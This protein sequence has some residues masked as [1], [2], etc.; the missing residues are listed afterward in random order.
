MKIATFNI[1]GIKARLPRLLEWLEETKPDVACLQEIKCLDEN[2]PRLEFEALGYQLAI[3]G[4]K[5]FNG[6]AIFSRHEMQDIERGLPGDENDIQSRYLEATVKGVRICCLYLPN[7]N[8]VPGEKFDYKLAWMDRLIARAKILLASEVPFLMLG[9]FNV[10]QEEIDCYD[11]AAFA[12]DA[13]MQPDARARFRALK[14]LGLTDAS[15]QKTPGG[16]LYTFWDYQR[17]AW[18]RDN[19]LRIDFLMLSPA[20]ADRL[21]ETGID[22]PERGKEKAS[23]HV[24]VWCELREVG[25]N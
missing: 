23:D 12:G 6:V 3:H 9:D 17:G 16:P 8:P 25:A 1:N 7:G 22:R 4:Q 5:G 14:Y 10:F 11:P 2:F 15:R 20:L 13:L 21:V 24:P 19:G 18:P